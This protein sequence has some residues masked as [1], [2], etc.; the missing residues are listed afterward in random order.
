MNRYGPYAVSPDKVDEFSTAIGAAGP[1]AVAPPTFAMT[2]FGR[3]LAAH[4]SAAG[5]WTEGNTVLHTRQRFE[6]HRPLYS[7]ETVYCDLAVDRRPARG[8]DTSCEVTGALVSPAGDPVV[9]LTT[10]LL[11]HPHEPAAID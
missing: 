1:A 4:L 9:T 8:A 2:L 10:T 3:A 5:L 7:G 6:Y 11:V